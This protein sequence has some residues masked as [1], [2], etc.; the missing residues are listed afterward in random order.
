MRKHIE[1]FEQPG[2]TNSERTLEL[3]R[4]RADQLGIRQIVLASTYGGTATRA[5]QVFP[6]GEFKLIAVTICAGFTS[7]GW[8]M[9]ESVRDELRQKG[10]M[11]LTGL[12]ALG[13]DVDSAFASKYGGPSSNQVAADTLRRF[14]QGM[15]VCVEIVLMVADAGL[16]DMSKEVIAVAGTDEGADTAIVVKPAYPRKFLELKVREIIALPR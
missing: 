11:V 16:L 10:V 12:H 15:K 6:T 14:S 13:D 8:V 4:E 1:Y 3:A 9:K 5:A 2:P 7:E